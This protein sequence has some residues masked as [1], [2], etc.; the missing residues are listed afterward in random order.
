MIE[1]GVYVS[2]NSDDEAK[3]ETPRSVVVIKKE[4][5]SI[6]PNPKGSADDVHYL[7]GVQRMLDG[8][9][10]KSEYEDIV[11]SRL[12]SFWA[13]NGYT[14]NPSDFFE[15]NS[16]NANKFIDLSKDW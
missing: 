12:G 1:D 5:V 8:A 9:N 7:S 4:K 2:Y 10:S 15:L 3:K 13:W 6:F 14:P 11:Y 16:D